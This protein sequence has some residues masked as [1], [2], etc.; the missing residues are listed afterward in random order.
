MRIDILLFLLPELTIYTM[1]SHKFSSLFSFLS[2]TLLL[3]MY[4]CMLYIFIFFFLYLTVNKVDYYDL[5]L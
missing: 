5:G 3:M 4:L 2:F 1:F